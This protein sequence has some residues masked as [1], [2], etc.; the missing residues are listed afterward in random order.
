MDDHVCCG[1]QM[2]EFMNTSCLWTY[3]GKQAV[4]KHFR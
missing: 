3:D 4:V 2:T 1:C